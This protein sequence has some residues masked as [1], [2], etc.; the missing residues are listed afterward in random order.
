[1]AGAVSS[2]AQEYKSISIDE[3]IEIALIVDPS[4]LLADLKIAQ[5]EKFSQTGTLHQPTQISFS[6]EEFNFGGVS[7]IQSLN[8]QQSFNLPKV[9]TASKEYFLAQMETA[10]NQK[11]LSKKELIKNVE[12]AYYTLVIA[13]REAEISKDIEIVYRNSYDRSS[14]E[15]QGGESKKSPML[16]T[17]PLLK[18]AEINLDHANHEV[19][20]SREIFNLWIGK[21]N[22]Y[23]VTDGEKIQL[24]SEINNSSIINPHLDVYDYE[25]EE[26][27]KSIEIQKSNLLPQL[28]AAARLQSLNG[29]LLYFGYQL[30]ISIPIDRRAYKR[31][32]EASKMSIELVD[33]EKNIKEKEIERRTLRL[34]NHLSHLRSKIQFYDSELIP[35]ITEQVSFTKD[36]YQLGEGSYLEYLMSLEKFNEMRLE[37]LQ[38]I[39]DFYFSSIE[40]KYWTEVN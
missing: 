37:K 7:G 35:S 17:Y 23:D 29:D 1:M 13:K 22:E 11:V 21:Q 30:G 31:K 28:N 39:K 33:I 27:I 26:I 40:L 9:S 5:K 14:L 32:I 2:T 16:S 20:V 36:A 10:S 25:K 4:I 24:K 12:L 8:I 3:A 34:R 18:K 15:F 6:G 19:E 38:L